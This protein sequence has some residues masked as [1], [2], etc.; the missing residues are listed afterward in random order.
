M[1]NLHIVLLLAQA[2]SDNTT[3]DKAY[4]ALRTKDYDH[5]I[6]AFEQALAQAPTRAALHKDLAYT[7]LKTGETEAA[8]D[9]FAEAMRL[10]PADQHV[11]MEY[12]FLCY[13]TKRQAEARRVFDRIRQLGDSTAAP[14]ADKAFENID[15]PLREGI[16][17]WRRA[18]DLD[19]ANF[20]AHEELARLA[21][22][23]DEL[24]LAA[25][26]YEAA[27]RLRPDR[28]ALLL[29]LGRVWQAL[30]RKDDALTAL[31]AA[32]RGAEPRTAEDA[33]ELLP[34]RYPFVYE[35]ERAL[36]LDPANIDLRR[37]LAYLH[38]EMGHRK[39]AET[40]FE[41]IVERAPED[42]LSTAQLGLLRL[43]RGDEN[44]A[45]PL[46]N[47][48]L[49][50]PDDELADRVRT[51]LHLPKVLHRR[52]ETPRADVSNEAKNLA[53]KSLEK[54]YL[55]DALKYL[56]VAHENDPVD[57]N[58]MLKL[59]WAYNILE[60]DE[61]A[62]KWFSLARRSPDPSTA[63]EANRAF[64]NLEPALERIKNSI[65]VSSTFSTR[66]NDDFTYAQAKSELQIP[67]W[68]V[69]PYLSVRFIGDARGQVELGAAL[70]P[71]YLS[72]RSV[73]LGGGIATN[74]WHGLMAWFEAGEALRYRPTTIDTG[75]LVPDYRGGLSYNKGFGN[76]LARG[77]HGI[78]AETSADGIFVSRFANDLLLYSQ[79]RIGY[80]HHAAER[81][82]GLHAQFL[83][84]WNL[85]VDARGEYWA[86]TFETG[87][88]VR[89]RF[90]NW[91]ASP[92][93]SVSALT[94]VYLVQQGNPRGPTFVDLR[95]GIWYA[96]TR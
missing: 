80:T 39:V 28:R 18:V 55:K 66:W 23:R 95:I 72:E 12:A 82:G 61:E 62:V 94:G 5:A 2:A 74:A 90:E 92:I 1:S 63:A 53:E 69:H 37:E 35:F 52:P 58:V 60:D 13:E 41:W 81:A 32:S 77:A 49:A 70:G 78:F 42:L 64:H 29:D 87:P 43:S 20:S 83:W 15:R 36:A 8:R 33:R 57:F 93:F 11:A 6:A 84:N 7:L 10:D 45:M 76:L 9:H 21:D 68:A 40:H 31:L 91:P 50:G 17:R 75:R 71:Q 14:I 85:T 38:L 51:A 46:L 47:K 19:P 4:E 3:L 27:W 73:V 54:G 30:G 67:H 59:G 34:A 89:L 44:A 79:S 25:E 88:G 96:L 65:W 56:R 24:A 86:N 26:H 22:Q 16:A 48:V